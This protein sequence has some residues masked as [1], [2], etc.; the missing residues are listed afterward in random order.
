M[1][2]SYVGETENFIHDRV[3]FA[4]NGCINKTSKGGEMFF[5]LLVDWLTNK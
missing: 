4:C 3:D 2:F 1:C 5:D